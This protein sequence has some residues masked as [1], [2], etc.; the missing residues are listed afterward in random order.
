VDGQRAELQRC[1]NGKTN[2]TFIIGCLG[3]FVASVPQLLE[4][5]LPL[6][7]LPLLL[8]LPWLL[9]LPKTVATVY[10]SATMS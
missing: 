9:L 1:R 2:E 5:L 3:N 10:H 4:L 7:L 6:L 8:L